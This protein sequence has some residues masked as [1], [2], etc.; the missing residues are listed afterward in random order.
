MNT[1]HKK[2]KE[3]L[4]LEDKLTEN[5]MAQRNLGYKL[6][7]TPILD[8][9]NMEYVLR[10]DIAARDDAWMYQD[11]IDEYGVT[12]WCRDKSFERRIRGTKRTEPIK[13]WFKL[14]YEGE[15][16]D[17]IAKYQALWRES[18][19]DDRYSFWYGQEKAYKVNVPTWFFDTKI[20]KHYRTHYKVIDEVLLQEESY[21]SDKLYWSGEFEAFKW[22]NGGMKPYAKMRNRSDRKHNK[23]TLQHNLGLIEPAKRFNHSTGEVYEDSE[24]WHGWD[25]GDVQ[26]K[27]FRY[28]H[29]HSAKWDRW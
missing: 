16:R 26:G 8:G 18:P 4:R 1:K 21:L 27:E 10:K 12:V 17:W 2:Y 6:L 20:T 5:R 3:Y 25:M 24:D 9:Y 23:Q 29:K 15:Y 28:H 11:L 14:I 22:M 13:P 19:K 7:D